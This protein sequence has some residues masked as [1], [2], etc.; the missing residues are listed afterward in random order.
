MVEA[1][2]LSCFF[3]VNNKTCEFNITIVGILCSQ[4]KQEINSL[5]ARCRFCRPLITFA[6]SLDKIRPENMSGLIWI[7]TV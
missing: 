1:I 3:G 6:N 2:I 4:K 7:Q 5:P